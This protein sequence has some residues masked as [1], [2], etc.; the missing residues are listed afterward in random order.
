[1]NYEDRT[2]LLPPD[3]VLGPDVLERLRSDDSDPVG[4]LNEVGEPQVTEAVPRAA[5]AAFIASEAAD[6]APEPALHAERDAAECGYAFGQLL[7]GSFPSDR[8]TSDGV[9]SDLNRMYLFA[10]VD[11]VDEATPS[12]STQLSAYLAQRARRFPEAE[13]L[14]GALEE[15]TS[16]A[17]CMGFGTAVVL[18]DRR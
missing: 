11:L 12:F 10:L 16:L 9:L 18:A 3:A 15:A 13:A 17:W 14:G 2:D 5:I 1:M 8:L 6:G 4:C 7:L